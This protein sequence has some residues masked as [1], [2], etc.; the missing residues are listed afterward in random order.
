MFAEL[1]SGLGYNESNEQLQN[2][3]MIIKQ[4]TIQWA[5]ES[6]TISTKK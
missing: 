6:F 4:H 3:D 1:Y 2:I 5:P